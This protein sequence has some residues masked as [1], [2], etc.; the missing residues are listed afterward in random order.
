MRRPAPIRYPDLEKSLDWEHQMAEIDGQDVTF[1][2]SSST[3]VPKLGSAI[4]H[5]VYAGK[6]VTLRA[7][8]ADAIS[9]A[10]KAVAVAIGYAAPRGYDLAT[11]PGFSEVTIPDRTVTAMTFRVV[12]L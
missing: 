3:P 7:I 5:A 6:T 12:V 10:Q 4:A 9:Q 11:R 2:V 1:F 8:G